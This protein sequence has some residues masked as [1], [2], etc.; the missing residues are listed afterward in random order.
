MELDLMFELGLKV[1]EFENFVKI[2]I[3]GFIDFEN[4]VQT[5]I[6]R[7]YQFCKI[8]LKLGPIVLK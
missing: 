2:R 4:C 8:K 7:T 1:L 5:H 3:V 6:Q